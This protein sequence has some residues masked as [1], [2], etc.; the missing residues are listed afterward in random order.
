MQDKIS[1]VVFEI[2]EYLVNLYDPFGDKTK[3]SVDFIAY[4]IFADNYDI[5]SYAAKKYILHKLNN[6][7][8]NIGFFIPLQVFEY[9]AEL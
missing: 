9:V 1:E 2:V 5:L 7:Q 4:I 3:E 8:E 6:G